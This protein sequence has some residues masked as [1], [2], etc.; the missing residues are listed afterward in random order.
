MGMARHS[1][2]DTRDGES[3]TDVAVVQIELAGSIAVEDMYLVT[4][5]D[6]PVERDP[7]TVRVETEDEANGPD[8]F[9]TRL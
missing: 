7:K 9:N 4:N 3:K 2:M 5:L 1:M 6:T 8:D